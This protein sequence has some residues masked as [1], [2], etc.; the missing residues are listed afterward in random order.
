M[1][2]K[3]HECY[4]NT[5]FNEIYVEN[6]LS[7]IN[8]TIYLFTFLINDEEL[9]FDNYIASIKRL[10]NIQFTDN[11]L[12]RICSFILGGTAKKVILD[13]DMV[14]TATKRIEINNSF[15]YS[16]QDFPLYI[17]IAYTNDC[18]IDFNH[19][20]SYDEI[21]FLIDNN[22]IVLLDTIITEEDDSYLYDYEFN[23]IYPLCNITNNFSNLKYISDTY[24]PFVY[25]FLK[26]YF[27]KDR[28]KSDFTN[29]MISVKTQLNIL[30]NHINN[31]YNG[32]FLK[33]NRLDN[34]IKTIKRIKEK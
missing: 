1:K 3:L 33:I 26:N 27:N 25:K 24:V 7:E 17:K 5:Y 9:S 23:D 10:Y 4:I 18:N 30:E 14:C 31:V 8:D 28:L 32:Y 13:T 21:K 19:R 12:Y 29:Y 6:E 34:V 15:K 22:K 16:E 11:D 2:V 20:Y